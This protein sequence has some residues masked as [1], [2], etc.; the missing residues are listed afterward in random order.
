EAG[1]KA[2]DKERLDKEFAESLKKLDERL[3]FERGLA[4]W[5]YV[6]AGKALEPLLKDRTQLT[7]V[8]RKPPVPGR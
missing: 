8:P 3:K 6:V 2:A 5:T 4:A 7:A 1:E